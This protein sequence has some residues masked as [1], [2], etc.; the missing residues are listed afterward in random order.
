MEDLLSL[1]GAPMNWRKVITWLVI[2]FAIFY[3]LSD[4]SG[5]AKFVSELLN[6]LK[7]AAT[8]LS[9]FVSAL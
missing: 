2:I 9:Q 6:G 7:S 8:S 4:P 3:L 1:A 5:A